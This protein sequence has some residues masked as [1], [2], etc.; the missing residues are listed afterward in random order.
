[1]MA[2]REAKIG[3]TAIPAFWRENYERFSNF[4][5]GQLIEVAGR[6]LGLLTGAQFDYRRL[7]MEEIFKYSWSKMASLVSVHAG[8][9]DEINYQKLDRS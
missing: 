1:M 7:A 9:V 2:E 8:G 6:G 5:M 3:P 4:W